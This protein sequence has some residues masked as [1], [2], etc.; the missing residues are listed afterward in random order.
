MQ[1]FNLRTLEPNT[2]VPPIRTKI[3]IRSFCQD[4]LVTFSA[5][6]GTGAW[7]TLKAVV[8]DYL[9][10]IWISGGLYGSVPDDAYELYVEE[11]KEE[12]EGESQGIIVRLRLKVALLRPRQFEGVETTKRLEKQQ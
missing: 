2:Y 4:Q 8:D 9:H 10:S 3:L 5:G 6:A 7:R 12:G 11:E 1:Q